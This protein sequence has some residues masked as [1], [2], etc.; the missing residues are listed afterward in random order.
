MFSSN[1]EK[2]VYFITIV[3]LFLIFL[4]G[5]IFYLI[6]KFQKK[7]W[8]NKKNL[9]ELQLI[10]EN[11]LLQSKIQVQEQTFQ[12]ISREIHDNIGQKLSLAKLHLNNIHEIA[13]PAIKVTIQEVVKN[14]TTCIIDLRDI[15]RSLSSDVIINNGFLKA[16]EFEIEQINKTFQ[17]HISL[18]VTGDSVFMT[19]ERE[20]TVF[21]IIQEALHNIF[22]HAEAS[23][24]NIIVHFFDQMLDIQV[25]DNGK[26][27]D[28]NHVDN[29]NGL[30][31]IKNRAQ[32][33]NGTVEFKSV[34]RQGTTIHLKLPTY[35]P[36]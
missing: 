14:I 6:Y 32:S 7:Q 20:L 15:S 36:K 27:F 31:N 34:L 3:T 23:Q 24:I 1:I 16:L 35:E 12:N 25:V 5:L 29:S 2:L 26:G 28:V 9:E 22:K 11:N 8:L 19:A 13:S 18:K 30:N 33:I 4:G 17:Y 10:H 21:R